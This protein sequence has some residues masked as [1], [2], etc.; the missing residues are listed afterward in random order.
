[1]FDLR[2]TMLEDQGL[3]PT[4]RHFVN[5]YNRFFGMRVALALSEPLPPLT[6]EQDLTIFRIV[7]E[8]LQNV[9]KHAQVGEARIAL[10][11]ARDVLTLRI[12]DHGR[13]FDPAT[14]VPRPGT[15]AG[16]PGMRERAKLIGA[17]LTVQ[18]APSAGTTLVVTMALRPTEGALT[19]AE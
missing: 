13:G 17:E 2:P 9:R 3:G 4:L 5:E 15:G 10:S 8:A 1:M 7:Q 14:V 11:E 16:L 6:K 12:D 19:A 18:S